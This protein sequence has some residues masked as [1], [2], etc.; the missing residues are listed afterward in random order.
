MTDAL[1]VVDADSTMPPYQQIVDQIRAL[2]QSGDLQAGAA[3][4][5]IRQL[6]GDLAVAPNTVAR[7]Y[8]E[9]QADGWIE[10]D[11]RRGT[12]VAGVLPRR[13]QAAR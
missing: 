9:L 2:V 4:P 11:G 7:A 13:R 12:R 10:A 6:A 1:I 3:L 5:T 8:A